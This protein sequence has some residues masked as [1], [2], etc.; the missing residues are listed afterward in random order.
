MHKGGQ[1][2]EKSVDEMLK[3]MA[4]MVKT[5]PQ[6]IQNNTGISYS[7]LLLQLIKPYQ[8]DATSYYELDYLL[9]TGIIAW[10]LAVYKQAGAVLPKGFLSSVMSNEEVDKETERLI[11]KLI[12]D[13]EKYFGKQEVLLEDYNIAPDKSGKTV[14]TVVSKPFEEAMLEGFP[15]DNFRDMFEDEDNQ[16][17]D[18]ED[19]D[20]PDYVV[21]VINRNAVIVKA[22]G[23]F[24]DW[25]R[26]IHF[27][28]EPIIEKD[29]DSIYLLKEMETEKDVQKWLKKTSTASF[30]VNYGSG[31]WMKTTGP[32]TELIKCLPNGLK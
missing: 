24:F 17:D 15:E 32:K 18:E 28:N 16:I 22:K 13:M 2:P 31:I 25:L 5:A 27:P 14:V 10:N 12:K 23:P 26:K 11:D 30:A 4:G 3:K 1:H 7:G 6:I 29:E 19:D 9:S 8:K 21:P 20:L